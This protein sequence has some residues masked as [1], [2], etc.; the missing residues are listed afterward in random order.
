MKK[1]KLAT[2]MIT[3]VVKKGIWRSS[4]SGISWVADVKVA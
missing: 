3:N 4:A 1:N 2:T